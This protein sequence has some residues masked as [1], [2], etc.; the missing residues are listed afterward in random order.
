MCHAN[1]IGDFFARQVEDDGSGINA[2]HA[3]GN[4]L[5]IA[6]DVAGKQ[7][8]VGAIACEIAQAI[9]D[10]IARNRVEP[11]RS[12]IKNQQVSAVGKRTSKL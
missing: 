7:H 3:I 2:H 8:A 5:K 11:R 1:G 6:G 4:M 12:L 9:K 10:L